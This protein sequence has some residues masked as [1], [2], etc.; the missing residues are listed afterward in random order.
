MDTRSIHR[1]DIPDTYVPNPGAHLT[2]TR[3]CEHYLFTL[4][5][6]IQ[7]NADT[8]LDI[9]SYDGWHALLLAL[10]GYKVT[11][12]EFIPELVRAARRYIDMTKTPGVSFIEAGWLEAVIPET[13]YDLITAYEVLEHVPLE[14]VPK[15][16]SKMEY[17]GKRILISVPDQDHKLNPQ[18]QW[19]PSM[20]TIA[21]LFQRKK[22]FQIDYCTYPLNKSIPN[23]WFIRYDTN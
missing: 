21:P 5:H 7:V 10:D 8:I 9:G 15:W 17:Y 2:N 14:E 4:E 3:D 13:K 20:E 23:N 19:T 11:G 18:H 12:V 1:V 22:N 16:I 6:A